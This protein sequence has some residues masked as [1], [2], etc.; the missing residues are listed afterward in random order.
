MHTHTCT[1]TESTALGARSTACAHTSHALT[2][3][4][5]TRHPR[6]FATALLGL[7]P[8]R[9]GAPRGPRCPC[10]LAS[11]LLCPALPAGKPAR[12]L[13]CLPLLFDADAFACRPLLCRVVVD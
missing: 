1:R 11:A 10:G 5:H 9:G 8:P 3:P 2:P 6:T 13:S 4:A 7:P 12:R